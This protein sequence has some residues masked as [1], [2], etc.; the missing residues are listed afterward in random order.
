MR[1]RL[2]IQSSGIEVQLREIVLCDKPAEF[3]AS[4]PKGTVPVVITHNEVIDESFE[5]MIWALE[6]AD[7]EGWLKMPDAGY[8]WVSRNDGQFKAAL[9]H[10]KYSVRHP[11][12]DI[13]LEREK[14]A[15]F[16]HDLN[17][18]MSK[19]AWMFGENCS[20]ADIAILPFVRQFSNIDRVWFDTQSWQHLNR[21]LT[22]FLNSSRFKSIMTRYDKWVVGSPVVLF[23]GEPKLFSAQSF[24]V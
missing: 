19:G 21:W 7:P 5:I 6:H 2:A 16:L 3:L 17:N 12:L 4:S 24:T 18:V 1:A 15:D 23:P 14:A 9:D 8:D 10:T 11:N 13:H 20:L 22:A